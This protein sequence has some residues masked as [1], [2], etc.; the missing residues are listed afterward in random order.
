[1]VSDAESGCLATPESVSSFDVSSSNSFVAEAAFIP[2]ASATPH[3]TLKYT[4]TFTV[5]LQSRFV[6]RK[7]FFLSIRSFLF[8]AWDLP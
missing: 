6:S 8:G 4:G 1:M 2:F 7:I 5:A 3:A